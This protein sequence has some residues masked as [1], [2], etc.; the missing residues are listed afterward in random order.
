MISQE[1]D[2]FDTFGDE[3]LLLQM[4]RTELLAG[5][6]FGVVPSLWPP[7]VGNNGVTRLGV[8]SESLSLRSLKLNTL[9]RLP[10]TLDFGRGFGVVVVLITVG[11]VTVRLALFTEV[12]RSKDEL[13]NFGSVFIPHFG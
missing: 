13:P 9:V 12:V 1:L 10:P 6:W 11:L 5:L 2:S 4:S 8:E 3:N 7:I